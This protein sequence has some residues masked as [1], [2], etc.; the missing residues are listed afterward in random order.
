MSQPVVIGSVSNPDTER[1][2]NA[3]RDRYGTEPIEFGAYGAFRMFL[4]A[5]GLD[6]SKPW[7]FMNGSVVGTL[8]DLLP[9]GGER[10]L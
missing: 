10:W 3:A 6:I 2:V 8:S 9:V 1:L 4:S 7:L 5:S